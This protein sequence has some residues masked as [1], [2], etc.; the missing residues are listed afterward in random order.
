MSKKVIISIAIV[1][2]VA[3][4]ALVF[5]VLN[6]KAPTPFVQQTPA[7]STT[8]TGTASSGAGSVAVVTRGFQVYQDPADPF[9]KILPRQ[10][11]ADE[12]ALQPKPVIN[13]PEQTQTATPTISPNDITNPDYTNLSQSQFLAKY[14]PDASQVI[15]GQS[16]ASQDGGDPALI[17]YGQPANNT[18]TIP[19]DPTIDPT[20]FKTSPDNSVQ[21]LSDYMQ[22]I[23][24][25][26]ANL[27]LVNNVDPLQNI[28]Q[29]P[30]PNTITQQIQQT[31]GILNSIQN[32]SVPSSVIGMQQSVYGLYQNYST[33]L[34]DLNKLSTAGPQTDA[35][36]LA[37]QIKTDANAVM[38]SFGLVNQGKETIQAN[39]Q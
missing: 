33:F 24:T 37:N 31:Q 20:K 10:G 15:S 38:N 11:Q 14:Y 7:S 17:S 32:L 23:N 6:K 28:L 25:N 27:D 19:S 35:D 9:S 2:L 8:G 22:N 13:P 18:D 34:N 3:V 29:N 5:F 4:G 12:L 26:V 36:T 1:V 30:D 16:A 21:A 39:I